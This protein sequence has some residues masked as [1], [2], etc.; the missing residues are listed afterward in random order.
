MG[1]VPHKWLTAKIVLI[2]QMGSKVEA[3]NYRPVGLT[4]VVVKLTEL[5][6]RKGGSMG[7]IY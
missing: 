4:S 5:L 1:E 7:V 6:K 2:H 3:G